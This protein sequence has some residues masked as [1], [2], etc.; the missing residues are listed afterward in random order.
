MNAAFA[1]NAWTKADKELLSKEVLGAWKPA[2]KKVPA[3]DV[4]LL[5]DAFLR[6]RPCRRLC[7]CLCA[8]AFFPVDISFRG[9][10][11]K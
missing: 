8:Y 6:Q 1:P 7:L 3:G 11:N 9:S 2:A 10:S 5:C 4:F